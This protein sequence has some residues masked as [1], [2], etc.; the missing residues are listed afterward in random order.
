MGGLGCRT[1]PIGRV[2][3]ART[4]V[5][6]VLAGAEPR[7]LRRR[8][9]V[10]GRWRVS[11]LCLAGE[12][13]LRTGPGRERGLWPRALLV[14]LLRSGHRMALG[15]SAG[16]TVDVG[17]GALH[18]RLPAGG[19]VPGLGTGRGR[20]RRRR[21]ALLDLVLRVRV[22]LLGL[23]GLLG[24][25]MMLGRL[26]LLRRL[27]LLGVLG[28]L[29]LRLR[30]LG[31]L[32]VARAGVRGAGVGTGPADRNLLAGGNRW[33]RS[34]PRAAPRPDPRDGRRR[35][36]RLWSGAWHAAG[37]SRC[38]G[39][40]GSRRCRRTW[41][42]ARRWRGL[43]LRPVHRRA[44]RRPGAAGCRGPNGPGRW[45]RARWSWPPP[46]GLRPRR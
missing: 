6:R 11:R 3:L 38:P 17:V 8:G 9:C 19:G 13:G 20:A 28:R 43:P 41:P 18:R 5:T 10:S 15:R 22:L 35:A 7:I 31:L 34:R 14:G 45:R 12:G 2:C 25:L 39:V 23:L 29:V 33:R 26:V 30:R 24:R 46:P 16:H 40:T 21:A 37:P 42:R 32:R 27:V 44:G 36:A 4:P 1:G